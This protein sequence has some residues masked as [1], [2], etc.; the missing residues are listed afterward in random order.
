MKKPGLWQRFSNLVS[1]SSPLMTRVGQVALL[2][3]C[4]L[5]WLVCSLPVVTTGAAT[6]ALYAVLLERREL[7]FDTAFTAFFRAFR[8]CWRTA[9]ALWL[10][11]L[12][13]GVVWLWAAWLTAVQNLL[14]NAFALLPLLVS[15]AVWAFVVLWLF[16]LLAIGGGR[17]GALLRK[18]FLLGLG[19]L[20]RSMVMLVI[21]LVPLALFFLYAKTFMLLSGFWILLGFALLALLKLLV[22]EP[23]LRRH[24]SDQH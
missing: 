4:N 17:P 20:W 24:V 15:G 6:T 3:V 21:E 13:L 5:C 8:R 7:S 19:E 11:A 12:V 9:T 23:V 16:P 1:D 10:P 22:M 18:A 2:A 14:N